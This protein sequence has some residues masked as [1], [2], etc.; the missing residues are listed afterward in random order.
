MARTT[1][2]A[3]TQ[4]KEKTINHAQPARKGAPRKR[5]RSSLSE[6][7]DQPATKQSRVDGD[8]KEEAPPDPD[9]PQP[10]EPAHPEPPSSG[11]VPIQP[12]DAEKILEIL[13]M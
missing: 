13:E 4:E 5:K 9:E 8:V 1:R 3:T 12:D 7:A 11:D 10:A 2:S 6:P